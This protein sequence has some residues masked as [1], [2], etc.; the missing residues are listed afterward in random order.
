MTTS[1]ISLVRTPSAGFDQPFEMLAA[2][3]E[4]VARMLG[5]L[6]RLRAHLQ[7]GSA[8][9]PARDAARDVMRYFDLAAPHHHQDEERHVFPLLRDSGDAALAVL[10]ERLQAEHVL[11]ASAWAGLRPGLAELAQGRWPADAAPQQFVLWQAFDQLYRGHA[12][13]EDDIAYPA[14]RSRADGAAQQAMGDEMAGRR[15]VG[16]A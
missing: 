4:R 6:Q 7:A 16:P 2:C 9:E 14:A 1:P 15:G 8:D 5:L 12:Q 13:A 10:A 11:M 3:H